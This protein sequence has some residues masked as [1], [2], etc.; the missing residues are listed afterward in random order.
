MLISKIGDLLAQISGDLP[1]SQSSF[2]TTVSK[3]KA[4]ED[5]QPAANKLVKKT[6]VV[7]NSSRAV[8]K[9]KPTNTAASS[10]KPTLRQSSQATSTVR[11]NVF[12]NARPTIPSTAEAA[13]T[14]KKGSFAEIMAR[15]KAAQTTF[16]PIGKIQHKP[17]EKGPTK[18][19]RQELKRQK[20]QPQLR[21]GLNGK[22]GSGINGGIKDETNGK[23]STKSLVQNAQEKKVKKAAL[24]T[25]GY[26]GTA[27][28]NPASVKPLKLTSNRTIGPSRPTFSRHHAHA[29]K[30]EEEEDEEDEEDE[31]VEEDYYSDASSDMEAAVFEV[32]EEEERATRIARKEDEEA[33]REEARL[34]HE[35]AGKRRMLAAM[36]RRKR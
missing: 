27:R 12:N 26:T 23:P 10:L 2:P 21:R 17:I 14:P 15:G 34:K 32:D 11:T 6:Q 22:A 19:E 13:K 3:R 31:E 25:T 36:A 18:R 24:A 1:S 16:G 4:D 30:E 33:L 9:I 29:D 8:P 28:S 7:A 20:S 5:L 35:K